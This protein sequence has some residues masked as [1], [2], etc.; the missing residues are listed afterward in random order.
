M[1]HFA[2][3]LTQK[4]HTLRLPQ[5][6]RDDVQRHVLQ[7]QTTTLERAPFR[8]QL[9]FWAFSIATAL[10]HE[11]T[12]ID[13]PSRR[14][15]K[16]FADT[17]SVIID[18]WL[19]DLLAVTAF[20]YLGSEHDRMDD[21]AQ[22]IEVNNQLAGAG[23]SVVLEC[24]NDRDLRL[25]AL[26][27][28]LNCAASMVRVRT[29]VV[30]PGFEHSGSNTVYVDG[31]LRNEKLPTLSE[32]LGSMETQRVEFKKTARVAMDNDAPERVINE[33]IVKTVAAFLNTSGGTL[34][35]GIADDGDILGLQPDLDYKN[36]DLDGY[37][38]WLTTLLVN[39]IDAGI[40]G[41]H[42]RLRIEP[43]G[44]K[45][46]CLIDVEPS[47]SPV[48]AKTTKGDNC[49]YVRM[50]NTT[51]MLEGPHIVSYIGGHWQQR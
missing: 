20:H 7:H 6:S 26:D 28:V 21:P 10:A 14:W 13:E 51:R 17:R 34:G 15:G 38:N 47:P 48:Y 1:A 42:V 30:K 8:R 18:D 31:R 33:G 32:L 5:D 29:D 4:A 25:T 22:I 37:Q 44:S 35:I 39:T 3:L 11:L 2:Q 9:D 46:V 16:K 43:V 27:K 49:F 12:P 24:L 41:A 36:Q 40:V 45:V 23:C 50:N 19:C